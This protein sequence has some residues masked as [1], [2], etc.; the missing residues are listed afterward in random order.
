MPAASESSV[1]ARV[2]RPTRPAGAR[3]LL[4]EDDRSLARLIQRK[5]HRHNLSVHTVES[6]ADA[7][8]TFDRLRPDLVLLDLDLAESRGSDFIASV[9]TR[10]AVPVIAM[11]ARRSERDTVAALEL[12]ADD[13]LVK[14]CGLD[15]LLA[16]LRVALRH[17]A[18]PEFGVA[19]LVRVGTLE[20]DVERRQVLRAGCPIHVTPTEYQLLKLFATHPDQFL[21]DRLLMDEVWGPDW[22]GGEHILH[23]YVARLRKKVEDNPSAPKYLLTESGLGYRLATDSARNAALLPGAL[24]V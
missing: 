2:G 17:I 20:L 7:R 12:G 24:T 16:R 5:L 18:R 14:P 1:Q 15:E 13:Y 23:V 19:P 9:R 10:A 6:V 3:V 21:A 22:R 4:V 11:S 8:E